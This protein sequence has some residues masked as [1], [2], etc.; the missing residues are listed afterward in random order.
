VAAPNVLK[1]AAQSGFLGG[2]SA[3]GNARGT[4]EERAVKTAEGAVTGAAVGA[5]TDKLLGMLPWSARRAARTVDRQAA[6]GPAPDDIR[7]QGRDLFQILD[8]SG[9]AYSTTQ[10]QN[11]TR[12]AATDLR[13]AGYDRA[14]NARAN[15]I[16]DDLTGHQGPMTLEQLQNLRSRTA[17]LARGN[18]AND[19]RIAGVILRSIDNHVGTVDPAL[20]QLPPGQVGPIYQ[21]A[22]DY[23]RTASLADDLGWMVDKAERRAASTNSGQNAE[24]AIRQNLR[25]V[26]DRVTKPGAYNPY[27]DEQMQLMDQAVRGTRTQNVLRGTGNFLRSIPGASASG[28]AATS[29]AIHGLSTG[30]LPLAIGSVAFPLVS[31]GA[32]KAL[33]SAS[34][35]IAENAADQLIGNVARGGAPA[36]TSAQRAIMQ[37]P[38]T[39]QR[40]ALMQ[41]LG[42]TGRLSSN[43]GGAVGGSAAQGF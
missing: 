24:N 6:R 12:Q 8:N 41:A 37:G 5:A 32:S 13:Q 19:R 4:A 9:T 25:Q 10:A 18:D 17:E 28:G 36:L 3:A 42:I 27:S 11:L 31:Y 39:R 20:T 2:V 38:P 21:Q 34:R 40:L 7:Q 16:V 30:N 35:N 33:S 29:G 15:A 23:W 14:I 22:R 26:E 43:I 1:T